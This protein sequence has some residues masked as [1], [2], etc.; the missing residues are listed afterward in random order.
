MQNSSHLRKGRRTKEAMA[1]RETRRESDA[2]KAR[3]E[4]SSADDRQRLAADHRS[5]LA[6]ERDTDA[7]FGPD[8]AEEEEEGRGGGGGW[9]AGRREERSG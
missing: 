4:G 3:L 9:R 2:F 6:G 7:D 1:R 8:V 5:F